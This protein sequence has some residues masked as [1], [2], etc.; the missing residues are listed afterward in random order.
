MPPRDPESLAGF[1]RAA[2]PRQ[3]SRRL[4][5]SKLLHAWRRA[6]GPEIAKRAQPVCLESNGK[7][8]AA[9]SGSAWRQ[10]LSLLAPQVIKRLQEEG[11]E[12][13][14]L[15]L[16]SAP[17]PPR[18]APPP[19]PR[20]VTPQQEAAVH[21]QLREVSDPDLRQALARAWL[22]QIRAGG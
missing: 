20:E 21:H 2:L 9:V 18:V 16:V 22:A 13:N 10:E 1:L 4:P 17:A 8:A 15:K 19:P 11:L 5:S 14:S 7:L 6:V 3:V 12:V